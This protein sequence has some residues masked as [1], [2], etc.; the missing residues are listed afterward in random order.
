MGGK[1]RTKGHSFERLVARLFRAIYPDARR[2]LQYR[3]GDECPDVI[4][5]PFYIEC[6]RKAGPISA[7][8]ALEQVSKASGAKGY[9]L[10]AVTK[11]DRQPALATMYLDDYLEMLKEF[12][13]LR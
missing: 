11:R 7:I 8:A 9:N 4:A 12:E 5:G 6:K 1:S 13:D 10:V 3:D 2:G